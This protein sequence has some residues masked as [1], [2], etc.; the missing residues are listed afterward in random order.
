MGYCV[1]IR[2]STAVIRKKNLDT[3]YKRLCDLNKRDDLKRGGR[4]E[5]GK[6]KERWFSWM[7]PNYPA[8]CKTTENILNDL[9]FDLYTD[10]KGDLYI[11]NYDN[12]SGQEDLFLETISDLIEGWIEW[13]GED[14]YLWKET[15]GGK[16]VKRVDGKIVYNK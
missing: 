4:Y 8:K 6:M 12:K 11:T 15:F 16:K 3:A 7:D 2:N 1:N 9:G 14:G 10:S 13:S 5:A